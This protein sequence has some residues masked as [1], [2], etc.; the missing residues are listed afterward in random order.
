MTRGGGEESHPEGFSTPGDSSPPPTAGQNDGR[1]ARSAKLLD[2]DIRIQDLNNV[3]LSSIFGFPKILY[4]TESPIS[5]EIRVVQKGRERKLLVNGVCQSVNWDAPG[6]GKRVWGKITEIPRYRDIDI[7][8]QDGGELSDLNCFTN[9]RCLVL[10]LG[11]GTAAHLLTRQFPGIRVDGVELDPAIIEVGKGFFGLDKIPNLNII[12]ADA[13]NVVCWSGGGG[14]AVGEKSPKE[15]SQTLYSVKSLTL[16]NSDSFP[17]DS[18]PSSGGFAAAVRRTAYDIVVVDLYCGGRFPEKFER[19]DFL[20]GVKDLRTPN[21]TAIFNRIFHRGQRGELD[22]FV[23][24]V[25][26]VFGRMG[27]AEVR[28]PGGFSNL[29]I[30]AGC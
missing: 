21:G 16:G 27:L 10:G 24:K 9:F 22:S 14:G 15:K 5:G 17:L 19:S 13:Y 25:R 18:E 7:P 1:N 2:L 6:I 26:R 12:C 3:P 20:L 23:E 8:R 29:L 28:G 30:V 11:G 4:Q